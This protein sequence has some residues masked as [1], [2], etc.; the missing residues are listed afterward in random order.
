ML[1]C[2]GGLALVAASGL[3]FNLACTHVSGPGRPGLRWLIEPHG[4][5]WHTVVL[6]T[7]GA[8]GL[9][10]IAFGCYLAP[11]WPRRRQPAPRR[12]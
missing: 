7:L 12:V 10:L 5:L 1:V 8:F 4:M 3:G 2:L 6:A 9:L 11:P